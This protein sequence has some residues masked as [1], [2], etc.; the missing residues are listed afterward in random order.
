MP[1]HVQG[2]DAIYQSDQL[3]AATEVEDWLNGAEEEGWKLVG[4]VPDHKSFNADGS[5]RG[6][7][8]S[9]FILHKD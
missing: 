8:G 3:S 2:I 6:T 4:V 9:L 7:I 1:Y 5:P